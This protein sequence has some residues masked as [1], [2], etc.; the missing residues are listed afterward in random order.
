MIS[1]LQKKMQAVTD[2]SPPFLGHMG[3]GS[4]PSKQLFPRRPSWRSRPKQAQNLD[5]RP[6]APWRTGSMFCSSVCWG[7]GT[8]PF[9]KTN[10]KIYGPARNF[11]T[12]QKYMIIYIDYM[13]ESYS[14]C[15]K[16]D[17]CC[18]LPCCHA[19]LPRDLGQP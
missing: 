14:R 10:M 12:H 18:L 11:K 15:E 19:I 16:L 8:P 6:S 3:C 2:S 4:F 7:V 9:G 17:I 13:H 5:F 1:Y